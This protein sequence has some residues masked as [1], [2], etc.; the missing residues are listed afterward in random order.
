MAQVSEATE[1]CA[2]LDERIANLRTG[3]SNASPQIY[4]RYW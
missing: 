3:V 1:C 4:G 2:D